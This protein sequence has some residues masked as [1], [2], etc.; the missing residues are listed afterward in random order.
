MAQVIMGHNERMTSHYS[1]IRDHEIAA[2]GARMQDG[3][4][5]KVVLSAVPFG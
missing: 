4:S 3:I 2:V 5:G 1:T